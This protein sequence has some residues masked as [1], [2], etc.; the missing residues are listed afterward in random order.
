M[1]ALETVAEEGLR[2]RNPWVLW[3][4]VYVFPA[5][6]SA[7]L[8]RKNTKTRRERGKSSSRL[9]EIIVPFDTPSSGRWARFIY[10]YSTGTVSTQ[11]KRKRKN[12]KL[13][14]PATDRMASEK[15]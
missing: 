2:V 9:L 6:T 15:G 5:E 13:I 11:R 12:M 8:S 4:R 10:K 1:K 3:E 7:V 14:P